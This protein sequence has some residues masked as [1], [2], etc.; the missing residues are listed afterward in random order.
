MVNDGALTLVVVERPVCPVC[1]LC[2][3]V[4]CYY[5]QLT[6]NNG[7]R[8]MLLSVYVCLPVCLC[9]VGSA[10]SERRRRGCNGGLCRRHVQ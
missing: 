1:H 5:K 3:Y 7:T 2:P 4:L 6:Q 10:D 8:V 9:V